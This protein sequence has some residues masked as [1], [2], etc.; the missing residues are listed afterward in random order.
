[1]HCTFAAGSTLV[2]A[3]QTTLCPD[4]YELRRLNQ[5]ATK[6]SIP[7]QGTNTLSGPNSARLSLTYIIVS[8]AWPDPP[9]KDITDCFPKCPYRFLVKMYAY[10]SLRYKIVH[11]DCKDST[12]ENMVF[13][14]PRIMYHVYYGTILRTVLLCIF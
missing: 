6:G 2:T 7:S 10:L 1:M 8:S 13:V 12:V 9:D 4:L 3:R 14:V 11:S 5:K